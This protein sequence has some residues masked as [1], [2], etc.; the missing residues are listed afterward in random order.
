MST[1][2]KYRELTPGEIIQPGDEWM[3]LR[4][5][6]QK[7]GFQTIGEFYQPEP[8]ANAPTRSYHAKHR[9]PLT[10]WESL[11]RAEVAEK[12]RWRKTARAYKR[13][14]KQENKKLK[15]QLAAV[16]KIIEPNGK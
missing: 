2:H 11:Y 9:R 5:E 7:A 16:M 12:D 14:L 15:R 13:V 4:G 6:A 10:D 8:D 1:E 3:D